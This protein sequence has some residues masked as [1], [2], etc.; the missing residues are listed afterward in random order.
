[1]L[2]KR[3]RDRWEETVNCSKSILNISHS[4]ARVQ[5]LLYSGTASGKWLQTLSH[6]ST[7]QVFPLPVFWD[8][9]WEDCS[10]RALLLPK[11]GN[12]IEWI[13][14]TVAKMIN[15]M[16]GFIVW[17]QI[18]AAQVYWVPPR[19]NSGLFTTKLLPSDELFSRTG[20]EKDANWVQ[21]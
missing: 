12:L 1:M 5:Y 6:E 15:G 20:R 3:W 11:R 13:K 14:R 16:M 18:A 2:R 7:I 8:Y 21:D 9:I 17:E 10:T 4:Q 19:G